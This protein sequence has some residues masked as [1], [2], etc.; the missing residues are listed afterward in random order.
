MRHLILF[1][2]VCFLSAC[3]SA[4]TKVD[5]ESLAKFEIGKTT[6]AQVVQQLGKPTHATMSSDGTRTAMYTYTQ[7]QA[8][9]ASFIPFVGLFARGAQ[10]E[11]TSVTLMFDTRSILTRYSASEGGMNVGTG[12]SSGQKQ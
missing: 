4:G 6:Y 5:Q 11:N 2:A 10:T 9:A 12:L 1:L 8:N 3:M 7:S